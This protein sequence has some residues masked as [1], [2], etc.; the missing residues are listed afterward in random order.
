MGFNNCRG[1]FQSYLPGIPGRLR[2]EPFSSSPRAL[3]GHLAWIR[4]QHPGPG[5]CSLGL[6]GA[7][8]TATRR[9]GRCH[10]DRGQE[11]REG[12]WGQ[13]LCL[14]TTWFDHHI[15]RQWSGPQLRLRGTAGKQ[16]REA[17]EG[18]GAVCS[19]GW[20]SP[21]WNLSH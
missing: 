8:P 21:F 20:G 5:R 1:I 18:R 15:P 10:P 12:Q 19:Q 9:G 3:D 4:A 13:G 16:G 17:G 6:A 14:R 11:T 7:I 2:W